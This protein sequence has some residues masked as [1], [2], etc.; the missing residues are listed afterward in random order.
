MEVHFSLNVIASFLFLSI[1]FAFKQWRRS[2]NPNSGR[3]LPPGPRKLPI[4]GNLHNL[5]GFVQHRALRDLA[6]KYGPLIHIQLGEVET[7]VVSSSR[8]AKEITKTHDLSFADRPE[9]IAWKIITYN[10]LDFGFS[11]YGEYWRQSRRLCVQELLSP[12][13]VRAYRTIREEEFS[14]L[15]S[16]ISKQVGNKID[17]TSN[18]LSSTFKSVSRA[19]FGKVCR[20]HDTFVHII[21]EVFRL[22]GGLDVADL[23]PSYK[24][25]HVLSGTER[26]MLKLRKKLDLIMDEVINEHIM[27]RKLDQSAPAV[28]GSGSVEDITDVLLRIKDSGDLQIPIGNDN[29]KA[30]LFDMFGGGTETSSATVEWAMSEMMKNP[31]VMVKAKNE[32]RQAFKGK[33]KIDEDDIQ[34]LEYIKL[35]IK[36]TLRLHP[37]APLLGP[38]QC[39]EECEIE[40]YKI[41]VGTKVFINAWAIARD[42]E[43][44]DDAESFI[45]ERFENNPI[46]YSGRHYEYI[47]FGAGRRMCP[48]IAFGLANVELPLALLL[49]HFDWEL[50]N[51]TKFEDLDMREADGITSSRKTHLYLVPTSTLLVE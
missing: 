50:P 24:I 44:W 28:G 2:K 32:I 16:N 11:P 33:K 47:P 25:L 10:G 7:I 40:G 20:D 19:T 8:L 17:L 22:A 49:Y 29:I 15:I 13:H 4:I 34:C 41:S 18:I 26:K 42:P 21:K 39:R 5:I 36:E 9:L 46:D 27:M 3:K 43:Y 37:P 23:F 30:I 51:E 45:P 14:D 48:G 12:K 38:R 1:F 35:I 31:H 6:R